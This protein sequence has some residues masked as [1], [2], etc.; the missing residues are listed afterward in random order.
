MV[1]DHISHLVSCR[2]EHKSR[3]FSAKS[4][5]LNEVTFL[6]CVSNCFHYCMHGNIAAVCCLARL[7]CVQDLQEEDF[8]PRPAA[9][10][11][12][13]RAAAHGLGSACQVQTWLVMNEEHMQQV[14]PQLNRL[15]HLAGSQQM[16]HHTFYNTPGEGMRLYISSN[17]LGSASLLSYLWETWS[18]QGS[19]SK[20]LNIH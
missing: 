6:I 18:A 15:K 10:G 7:N 1:D 11:S 20:E 4:R 2:S 13:G 3:S 5:W 19:C 16:Q 9:N 8:Q 14:Q 12:P 17:S